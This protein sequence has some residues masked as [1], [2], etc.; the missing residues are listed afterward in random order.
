VTVRF[1]MTMV[2]AMNH[3]SFKTPNA[4]ISTPSAAGVISGLRSALNGEPS[5]R[6]IDFTLHLIF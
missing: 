2:N 1:G 6:N 3:P 5:A 4:N